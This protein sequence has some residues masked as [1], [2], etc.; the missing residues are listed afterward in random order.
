[1]WTNSHAAGIE[2]SA[3]AVALMVIM[4][5]AMWI[6]RPGERCVWPVEGSSRL[7]LSRAID[8]EH[9]ATDLASADRIA[10]RYMLAAGD[11]N[12]DQTRFIACEA[13]LVQ[14]IA[15]GHQVSTAQVRA[16]RDR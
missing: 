10:R 6:D 2:L 9:L 1:M 16:T 5:V 14:A 3:V 15:T 11:R 13:T 8:R 12:Q 4:V 7:L